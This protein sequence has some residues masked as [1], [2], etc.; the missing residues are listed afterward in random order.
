MYSSMAMALSHSYQETPPLT[1]PT[2]QQAPVALPGPSGARKGLG[3]EAPPLVLV[4]GRGSWRV[5]QG[6]GGGGKGRR[7]R[8]GQGHLDWGAWLWQRQRR[9]LWSQCPQTT[10]RDKVKRFFPVNYNRKKVR[11]GVAETL[12]KGKGFPPCEL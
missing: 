2:P 6:E 10:G 12:M 7:G 9:L 4:A 1:P 11:G 8:R 3:S 5:G